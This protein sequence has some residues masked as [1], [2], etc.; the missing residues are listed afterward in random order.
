MESSR[1]RIAPPSGALL[2]QAVESAGVDT[3]T[4]FHGWW[5]TFAGAVL[6]AL[7]PGLIGVY[8]F[9]ASPIVAEFGATDTQ[10]GLGMSLA[11][12]GMATASPLAGPILDRGPFRAVM[13]SGIAIMFTS[14]LALAQGSALWQLAVGCACASIGIAL[15]GALPVQVLLIR[16]FVERRGTALAL[17]GVGFSVGS[18]VIP[19]TAAWL[20]TAY[21]WRTAV[22]LI[23]AG[24]AASTLA[25]VIWLVVPRPED[26]GQIPDGRLP[27]D[28]ATNDVRASTAEIP[29][30]EIF[31][32]RNFWLIGFGTGMALAVPISVLFLVRHLESFGIGAEQASLAFVVMGVA[33]MVGKLVTGTLADRYDERLI[34]LGAICSLLLGW[35]GLSQT[36]SLP[37]VLLAGIPAGFGAGGMIP[38]PGVLVG[39]CF[40]RGVAGRVMGLQGALGLPFLLSVPPLVGWSRDLTGSFEI[41]FLGLAGLLVVATL[42]VALL[43]VPRNTA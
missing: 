28:S 32:D 31:H 42:L 15:Y 12:L 2:S 8:G 11:I 9:V 21:G 30:Q 25:V 10:V 38:M 7:G 34:T 43:R 40:G 29:M 4:A 20:I 1:I 26:L 27:S 3:T 16:W 5:I 13:F 33:G 19:P 39:A 23:A 24:A 18:F 17:A 36:V 41:P 35:L 37:G 22:C 14:M 6:Q